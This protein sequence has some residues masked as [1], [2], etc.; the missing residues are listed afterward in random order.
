MS[1]VIFLLAISFALVAVIAIANLAQVA[2]VDHERRGL[3]GQALS[4]HH[5]EVA[6]LSAELADD[7]TR[8]ELVSLAR[9]IDA[10]DRAAFA[11][12]P[13]ATCTP[14][15]EQGVWQ[16]VFRDATVLT[17]RAADRRTLSRANG[18]AAREPVVVGRVLPQGNTA[19]VELRSPR[20]RPLEVAFRA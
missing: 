11:G 9:M 13:I 15:G 3:Y 4:R 2:R 14:A 12:V 7:E 6:A 5:G 20:H 8:S 17:V 18:L 10:L 19:I 16:V 1:G